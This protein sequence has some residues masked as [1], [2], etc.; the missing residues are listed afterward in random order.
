MLVGKI[1]EKLHQSKTWVKNDLITSYGQRLY[2]DEE[3]ASLKTQI[4]PEAMKETETLHCLLIG[5]KDEGGR[6]LYF[7]DVFRGS[8]TY[9]TKEMT[10]LLEGTIQ[11]AQ[12]LGIDTRTPAEVAQMLNDWDMAREW[13]KNNGPTI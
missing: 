9:N 2:I 4:E 8:H 7:Y 3:K 12:E 1:A 10:D 13:E 11:E 5:C 6:L